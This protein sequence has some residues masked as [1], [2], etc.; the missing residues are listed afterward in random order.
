[1]TGT[2]LLLTEEAVQLSKFLTKMKSK[3]VARKQVR[4]RPLWLPLRPLSIKRTLEKP[5]WL[6]MEIYC[7]LGNTFSLLRLLKASFCLILNFQFYHSNWK[8]L[9]FWLFRQSVFDNT[10]SF[11]LMNNLILFLLMGCYWQIQ[12]FKFPKILLRSMICFFLLIM[13]IWNW[14]HIYF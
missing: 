9:N 7:F 14:S 13:N 6:L 8:K 1:M 2:A 10:T 11:L 5:N 12:K 4:S 3:G